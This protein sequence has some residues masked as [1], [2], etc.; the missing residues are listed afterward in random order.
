MNNEKSH[1]IDNLVDELFFDKERQNYI[2]NKETLILKESDKPDNL[3][4]IKIGVLEHKDKDKDKDKELTKEEEKE[5]FNRNE[6]EKMMGNSKIKRNQLDKIE[7]KDSKNHIFETDFPNEQNMNKEIRINL[8]LLVVGEGNQMK[9]INLNK[10]NIKKDFETFKHNPNNFFIDLRNN[11]NILNKGN[12]I[13]IKN[14]LFHI[15][16]NTDDDI[17]IKNNIINNLDY[18]SHHKNLKKVN[19]GKVQ[20]ANEEFLLEKNNTDELHLNIHCR[21]QKNE[22]TLQPHHDARYQIQV[23]ML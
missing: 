12:Q 19:C 17:T 13:N 15:N 7:V 22:N 3:N 20:E 2:E 9:G 8:D 4:N 14:N 11:I 1:T 6:I 5:N 23:N 18:K 16:E 10:Q 21:S